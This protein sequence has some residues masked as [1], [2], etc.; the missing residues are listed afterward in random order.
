MSERL[1]KFKLAELTTFRLTCKCGAVAELSLAHAAGRDA[2][3]CPVCNASMS[4]RGALQALAKQIEA[5]GAV[6]TNFEIGFV[7]PDP[8]K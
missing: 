1:L 4:G 5:L 3:N 2:H 8:A 7:L 6:G